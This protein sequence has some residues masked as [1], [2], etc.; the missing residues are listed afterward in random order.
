MRWLSLLPVLLAYTAHAEQP[1][2]PLAFEAGTVLAGGHVLAEAITLPPKPGQ[3]SLVVRDGAPLRWHIAIKDGETRLL[4]PDGN[5]AAK[6]EY[7]RVDRDG[8]TVCLVY[9]T[10]LSPEWAV[11]GTEPPS[12]RAE[13][14]P[15]DD[16]VYA[17]REVSC[18]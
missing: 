13:F 8:R 16:R 2:P 6:A 11:R 3:V 4:Q 18:P 12:N 9:Q 17:F 14:R 15:A 5:W 7:S 10:Y 1:A